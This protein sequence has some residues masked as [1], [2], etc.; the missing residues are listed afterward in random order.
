M[1]SRL[2]LNKIVPGFT[3][4]ELLIV[5]AIAGLLVASAEPTYHAFVQQTGVL[6]TSTV[7]V[8]TLRRAQILAQSGRGDSSWGVRIAT[9]TIV[10]F[11]GTSYATRDARYDDVYTV[12]TPV[13]VSGIS[14]IDFASFSGTPNLFGTTTITSTNTQL[15]TITVN[16][17]GFVTY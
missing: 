2:K 11:K 10:L 3:L 8:Q 15:I 12:N 13:A 16:A 4:I 1:G 5:L 7:Y 9:T 14:E 6:D 17:K